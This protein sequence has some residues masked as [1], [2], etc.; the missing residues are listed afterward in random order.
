MEITEA[1]FN[2]FKRLWK[3][4]V[5]DGEETFVFMERTVLTQYAGYVVEAMEDK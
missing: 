4:A 3:Q 1:Q 5:E 2:E